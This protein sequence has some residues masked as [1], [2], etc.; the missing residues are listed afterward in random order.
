MT[1][2]PVMLDTSSWP[3]PRPLTRWGVSPDGDLVYRTLVQFG[4][5]GEAALAQ[6]LGLPRRRVRTALD[7]L[8]HLNA[9]RIGV[10][11]LDRTPP[12]R[13]EDGRAWRAVAP[14]DVE[15]RLRL[16]HENLVR[17]RYLLR[18]RLLG[19]RELG[20][21]DTVGSSDERTRVLFG[22]HNVRGLLAELLPQVRGEFISASPKPVFRSSTVE[23]GKPLDH[24]LIDN[25]VRVMNLRVPAD[26]AADATAEHSEEIIR[27]GM[28]YRELDEVPAQ[29]MI[30]N[31][32]MALV[33]LVP[34]NAGQG[35][36]LLSDTAAVTELTTMFLRW[37]DRAQVV[38]PAAVAGGLSPREA[39]IIRLLAAGHTDASASSELGLSMRTIAYALRELM[40]R[41][42]VENRFQLGLALGSRGV[43]P[44]ATAGLCNPSTDRSRS[45]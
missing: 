42:Q 13:Q 15:A 12:T 8:G 19:L 26:P 10:G 35:A 25:G 18:R 21:P 20:L 6:T 45:S 3:V 17:N 4:P 16:R 37:W 29:L 7:E 1:V 31:R 39:A 14:D 30:F 2:S 40:N 43:A 9:A 27:R 23:A 32:S 34:T 11:R 36:L 44:E 33:P 28:A 22:L 24:I 41:Y 5:A 38:G